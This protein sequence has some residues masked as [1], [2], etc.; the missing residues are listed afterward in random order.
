M[1]VGHLRIDKIKYMNARQQHEIDATSGMS[2]QASLEAQLSSY[3][4]EGE[5]PASTRIDRV[6]DALMRHSGT[7]SEAMN[8]DFSFRPRQINLV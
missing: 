8:E 5:V 2:M 6:I 7:L 4:N 1:T 3:L